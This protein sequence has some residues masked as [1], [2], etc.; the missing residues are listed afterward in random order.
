MRQTIN[1]KTMLRNLSFFLFI[2]NFYIR[3]LEAFVYENLF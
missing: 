1:Y 3:D 2:I